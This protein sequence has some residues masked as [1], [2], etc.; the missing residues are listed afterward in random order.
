M[1]D[2]EGMCVVVQRPEERY[3]SPKAIVPGTCQPP[4]VSGLQP[5]FLG[6]LDQWGILL[7]AEL[8]L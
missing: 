1:E 7:T 4:D 8:F 2:G 5:N 3:V 6:P